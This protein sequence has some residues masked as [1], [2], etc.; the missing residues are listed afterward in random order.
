MYVLRCQ[1]DCEADR[2]ACTQ[3]CAVIR[4]DCGHPCS[5][6]CHAAGAT[7][8][9][10]SSGAAAAADDSASSGATT[11]SACPPSLCRVQV[12]VTCECGNRSEK[13]PC[14]SARDCQ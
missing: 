5:L 2:K 9:S 7:E 11:A 1:G 3:R 6:P 8:D 13:M 4:A 14:H 12:T 10:A